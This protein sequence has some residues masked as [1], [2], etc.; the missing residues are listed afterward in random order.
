VASSTPQQLRS[1]LSVVLTPGL[2]EDIDYICREK[3][4]VTASSGS[5]GLARC[6]KMSH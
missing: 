5:V 2:S 1:L 6:A 4:H 3:L